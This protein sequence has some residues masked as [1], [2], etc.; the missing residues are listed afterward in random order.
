MSIGINAHRWAFL[1]PG[2]ASA[3]I[4]A[5]ERLREEGWKTL[6]QSTTQRQFA[7]AH[8]ILCRMN[9]GQRG[10][11]LSDDV[12]LGKTTVAV[13][14]ALVFAGS[15]KRVRILAPNKMMAR[16]WRQELEVHI[17]A[18]AGFAKHLKLDGAVKRLCHKVE[19]L[20]A[21]T[22]EVSTHRKVGRIACDLL[23]IDEV[24]R[25]RS[26]H[27]KL[28]GKIRNEGKGV[29][30]V[31]VLTATPF[32]IDPK[33]LAKLLSWVGGDGARKPMWDYAQTLD[34]L[35]RGR[36][37]GSPEAIAHKLVNKADEA[38]EAMSPFV[39]R[40][41]IN[42]LRPGERRAFGE[43]DEIA[44]TKALDVPDELLE[45]MLRTD[46]ALALGR[47]CNTWKRKSWN[48]PRYHVANGQLDYDLSILIES[49][50]RQSN[51]V[52]ADLARYHAEIALKYIR[53]NGRHPKVADTVESTRA[54]V[55][56]GEKVL[57]FCD[58]HLPAAELTRALAHE[59]RWPGASG[60]SPAKTVWQS[61]WSAIFGEIRQK[62]EE[63]DG[64]KRSISRLDH[65]LAWLISDGVRRQIET[66]LGSAL[67]RAMSSDELKRLLEKKRARAHSKCD[68][69][70][71]HARQLYKQLVDRESGSTR[72]VLLSQEA[73]RLP[74]T[75]SRVAAVC[76]PDGHPDGD[77]GRGI[78]YPGQPDTTLAVFNSPFGPDVL[79]ATDSLS[80]GVDLHRF[81][82]HLIHHELDPSP[83]RTIQRN[84]R[85]R[86]VNSWAALT[87]QP[88]RILY[89]AL[90]GTRDE[91]LVAIMR[92]RL[93]QFDLLLGGILGDVDPDNANAS[94]EM[95]ERVLADAR[96]LRRFRLCID[97]L[98]K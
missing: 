20:H 2:R 11:L 92:Y 78:F 52:D 23:I 45:A 5:Y 6:V 4:Q 13:L 17:D 40:H 37:F 35:W 49:E 41:G 26:E 7:T 69:I 98:R 60:S 76:T 64:R 8:D 31:L 70:A 1:R 27:S 79:V 38:V 82:R 47:R 68:S 30:Y 24:H 67:R 74:G 33:D 63:E 84:G 90:G 91:K 75:E 66:W 93:Q 53:A 57:I 12:G 15:N 22:I 21:G 61:A 56:Q 95:V 88:I 62:A 50:V 81:C 80:E 96:G 36:V 10:V 44:C 39:I 55:E 32:S 3:Y 18:I 46:R 89:P 25:A 65:Y 48:D 77:I 58:H 97:S 94:P 28:T 34:D 72:A 29:N 54:F 73:T 85:L 59:L 43:V 83:I 87:G 42:D 16:R 14:C 51:D 9:R 19:R 71:N 86:R